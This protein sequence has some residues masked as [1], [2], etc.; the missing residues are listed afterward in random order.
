MQLEVTAIGAKNTCFYPF[1]TAKEGMITDSNLKLHH[2]ALGALD[3]GLLATFYS[4]VLG[5]PELARHLKPETG[6]LRS[7]W[8]ELGAGAVLMI[9]KTDRDA[10]YQTPEID[11]GLFL[12]ALTASPAEVERCHDALGE[13]GIQPEISKKFTKY[14]RD[15]EG[16]RF[17][18]SVYEFE[19]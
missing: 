1:F 7:V 16:N 12:L 13:A 10:R 5:L 6:E 9:E 18:L 4:S 19:R 2:L 3:V 14:Y 11:S 8:L 17:A 15:P